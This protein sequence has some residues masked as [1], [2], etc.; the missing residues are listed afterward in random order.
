MDYPD[1]DRLTVR[2]IAD[3][4]SLS[5]TTVSRSLSGKG[6]ISP[7][8]RNRVLEYVN[9]SGRKAPGSARVQSGNVT[10]VVPPRF[11]H[12][13]LPFLRKCMGGVCRMAAQRDYDVLLC[14]ADETS[15][16]Q[17]ERQ[18]EARKTDGVILSQIVQNDPCLELVRQY[19]IPFV[20]LGR[21]ENDSAVQVDNDH[22]AAGQ[23]MTDLL[24]RLGLRRIAFLGG[25]SR[26]MVNQDRLEGYRRGMQSFGLEPEEWLVRTGVETAEQLV[27]AMDRILEQGP[28]C[29]LCGDDS[30]TV[31]AIKELRLRNVNVPRDLR[32]ASL[33]DSELL[34]SLVPGISA[35]HFDAAALGAS[36]CRILL[37]CLA[38]REVS[39]RRVAGY[40]VILRD[41]TK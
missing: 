22:V 1:T 27:D 12:L 39:G 37:D 15:T 33:Y 5:M 8:T 16:S 7:E 31:S 41:S 3:A 35:V 29:L 11:V 6:R 21:L 23:E 24:L 19:R 20:A 2:E 25:S 34:E 17:L 18:L 30:L 36:G 32:V 13:D 9:R 40:Q 26:Y 14:Y 28:E 4:L 38:G 10:L